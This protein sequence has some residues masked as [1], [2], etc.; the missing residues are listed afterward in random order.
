[1]K[2]LPRTVSL[3]LIP[4]LVLCSLPP[5]A[6]GQTGDELDPVQPTSDSSSSDDTTKAILVG[7]L[8]VV[9]SVVFILGMKSDFGRS[10]YV[11]KA[12]LEAT[13]ADLVQDGTLSTDLFSPLELAPP[14]LDLAQVQDP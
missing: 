5:M 4:L 8:I 11:K 9:V 3:V 13:Y 12:E 7:L 1:M 14:E 2:N 10:R 6:S